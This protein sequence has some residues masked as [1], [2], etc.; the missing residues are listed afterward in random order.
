MKEDTIFENNTQMNEETI[1]ESNTQMGESTILDED[2]ATRE[3]MEAGEKQ[4]NGKKWA[5]VAMGGVS[6]I[7]LGAGL[8][9]AQKVYGEEVESPVDLDRGGEGGEEPPFVTKPEDTPT[10]NQSHDTHNHVNNVHNHTHVHT[11]AP[12]PNGTSVIGDDMPFAEAFAEARAEVGPGGVFVWHGGVYSTF[13]AE[14]WNAMTP[15]QQQEFIDGVGVAVPVAKIPTMPTPEHPEPW[16]PEPM[17]HEPE[18][19]VDPEDPDGGED[20]NGELVEVEVDDQTRENF[21]LGEDVHVVGFFKGDDTHLIAAYDNNED[22]GVDFAIVD[23]D[24]NHQISAP[25][26]IVDMDG[27]ASTVSDVAAVQA[28]EGYDKVDTGAD[29]TSSDPVE[30]N[31]YINVNPEFEDNAPTDDPSL[32][33]TS[34]DYDPSSDMPDYMDDVVMDA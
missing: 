31:E 4:S 6:G 16:G 14:E 28:E 21:D 25:D 22:G 23:V 11:T 26:L 33:Y 30:D 15:A 10:D 29:Y 18:D 3:T 32:H 20:G 34:N 8:L 2:T 7:L 19:P 5:T 1:L 24:D 17:P 27:N 12:A 9:Y 13:Y